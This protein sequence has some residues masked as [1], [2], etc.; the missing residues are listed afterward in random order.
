VAISRAS[1]SSIQGGLP[2]FNDIWDGT[3]ATSAYDSLGSVLLS[4]SSSSISFSNI[5]QTYTHL[6]IRATTR[7][8]R[9][10]TG[11]QSTTLSFNGDTTHTNYRS[12]LLY[13]AASTANP[14]AEANQLSGYYASIGYTA[15]ANMTANVFGLHIIDILDYANTSK[16]TTVRT[17]FGLDSNSATAGYVGLVSSLWMNTAAVS[18]ISMTTLPAA[19]FVAN[20]SVSLYGIK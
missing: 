19:N 20:T 13:Y 2:K 5:P 9:A 11:A 18:S 16:N 15:A 10:D 14:S 4:S 12:H 3:T 8:D 17:I 6:Q 7:N 1:N